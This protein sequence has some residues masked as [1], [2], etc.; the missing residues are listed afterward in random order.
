MY[1]SS[2]LFAEVE[3]MSEV[4]EQINQSREKEA[5]SGDE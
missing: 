1:V 3:D 4:L 5:D 2:A